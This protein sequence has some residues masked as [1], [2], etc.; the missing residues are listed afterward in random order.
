VEIMADLSAQGLP[1]SE[2]TAEEIIDRLEAQKNYIPSS[3]RVRREYAYT[4]LREYRTYLQD[5]GSN[6]K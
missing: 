6:L 5:R 2:A 4:L 1:A 3:D